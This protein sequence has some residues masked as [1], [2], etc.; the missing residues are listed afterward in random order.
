MKDS[1]G[2][3]NDRVYDVNVVNVRFCRKSVGIQKVA[4]PTSIPPTL[5]PLPTSPSITRVPPLLRLRDGE[6]GLEHNHTTSEGNK[7]LTTAK[8]NPMSKVGYVSEV[9]KD[10]FHPSSVVVEDRKYGA[11]TVSDW[12]FKRNGVKDDKWRFHST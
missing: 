10:R 4:P 3:F 5:S 7:V 11:V 6:V 9:E 8:I 2:E 1:V 12:L